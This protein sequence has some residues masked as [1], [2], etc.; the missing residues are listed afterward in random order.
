MELGLLR[1]ARA[2]WI[3][4]CEGMTK[5]GARFHQ[6]AGPATSPPSPLVLSLSKDALGH[7]GIT[8]QPVTPGLTK[9]PR[10][11]C[12]SYAPPKSYRRRALCTVNPRKMRHR[13]ALSDVLLESPVFR[14]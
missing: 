13:A 11:L 9:V 4:A 6:T 8:P 12:V 7:C 5:G 2:H 14:Q 1:M 3:P 10:T